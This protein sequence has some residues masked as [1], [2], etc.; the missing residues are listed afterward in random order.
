[1]KV[2]LLIPVMCLP[3]L[4]LVLGADEQK[5]PIHNDEPCQRNRDNNAYS[6]FVRNHIIPNSFNIASK[7]EWEKHVTLLDRCNKPTQTFIKKKYETK[8]QQICNGDGRQK[9]RNLCTSISKIPVYELIINTNC[10]V[11][12]IQEQN[13]RYVTVACDKVLN[14]CRPVHFHGS[15]TTRPKKTAKLCST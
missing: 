3:A 10:K 14:H 12:K 13:I 11:T 5:P 9:N 1:M 4:T 2:V 15:Q 7:P 8:V 6:K